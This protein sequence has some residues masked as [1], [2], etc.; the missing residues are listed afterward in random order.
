MFL[1]PAHSLFWSY[2][3]YCIFLWMSSPRL[4]LRAN[5]NHVKLYRRFGKS[6]PAIVFPGGEFGVFS[7]VFPL[8]AT[9][10]DWSPSFSEPLR[11]DT[12]HSLHSLGFFTPSTF[13]CDGGGSRVAPSVGTCG[14]LRRSGQLPRL[15]L[16]G[17]YHDSEHLMRRKLRLGNM[18]G[19]ET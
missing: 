18:T 13:L 3:I 19:P 9:A 11:K 2:V 6:V 12:P 14:D 1:L 7:L 4:G 17:W 15:L 16:Q 10:P 5:E 8:C